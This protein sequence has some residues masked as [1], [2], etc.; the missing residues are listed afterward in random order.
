[1]IKIMEPFN[2][3]R[4]LESEEIKEIDSLGILDLTME[5][6]S[7]LKDDLSKSIVNKIKEKISNNIYDEFKKRK[8]ENEFDKYFFKLT[9]LHSISISD[10]KARDFIINRWQ[11]NGLH[12]P[13]LLVGEI[14]VDVNDRIAM[15]DDSDILYTVLT[16]FSQD[17]VQIKSLENPYGKIYSMKE[18]IDNIDIERTNELSFG[19]KYINHIKEYR[20]DYQDKVKELLNNIASRIECTNIKEKFLN[21]CLKTIIEYPLIQSEI[22]HEKV[23]DAIKRIYEHFN[24]H[25]KNI[26]A[27]GRY[28]YVGSYVVMR[29]SSLKYNLIVTNITNSSITVEHKYRPNDFSKEYSYDD[30]IDNLVTVKDIFGVSGNEIKWKHD[31]YSPEYL[32]NLLAEDILTFNTVVDTENS[33]K[34]LEE[35]YGKE[36]RC[37]MEDVVLHIKDNNAKNSFIE[38][39]MC[40]LN[41]NAKNS[42]KTWMDGYVLDVCNKLYNKNKISKKH[43]CIDGYYYYVGDYLLIKNTFTVDNPYIKEITDE[44]IHVVHPRNEELFN[45]KFK[46]IEE[47]NSEIADINYFEEIASKC[48]YDIESIDYK[49]LR[50]YLLFFC[51]TLTSHK[52]QDDYYKEKSSKISSLI[53]NEIK[54]RFDVESANINKEKLLDMISDN[55]N[56]D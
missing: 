12:K 48:E 1:M 46:S 18:F 55:I 17:K 23:F 6:I 26:F 24:L 13:S 50:K 56:K 27:K 39:I 30:F 3:K 16:N 33:I 42:W 40:E 49:D 54:R 31:N 44:Y 15:K 2:I 32:C 5:D 9:F 4:Y 25:Q 11:I 28:V 53:N 36:M 14:F 47:L 22:P 29:D 21:L 51:C 45:K 52:L 41:P 7:S 10:I 43:I 38:S 20:H 37:F 35:I 34:C 8:F 19:N